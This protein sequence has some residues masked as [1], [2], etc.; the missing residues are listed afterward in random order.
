M[1]TRTDRVTA[2]SR[3]GDGAIPLRSIAW[4]RAMPDDIFMHTAGSPAGRK[5]EKRVPRRIL[6][7]ALDLSCRTMTGQKP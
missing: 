2:D 1:S 6:S 3:W 4:T 5:P 7:W